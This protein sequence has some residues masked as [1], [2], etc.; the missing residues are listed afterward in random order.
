MEDP[1]A[2]A[3]HTLPYTILSEDCFAEIEKYGI[4]CRS[5]AMIGV[6]IQME[7]LK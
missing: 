3:L 2:A 5:T 4:Y 6:E 1:A 7:Q